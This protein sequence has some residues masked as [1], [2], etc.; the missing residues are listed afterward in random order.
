MNRDHAGK[1]MMNSVQML[2]GLVIALTL[3]APS[4]GAQTQTAEQKASSYTYQTLY[5]TNLFQQN[6]VS[7]VQSA[8]RNML[9]KAKLVAMPSQNAIS[10]YS[11][12]EE[13]L[14]AQRIVS[15][16]DRADRVRKTYRLTYT[17]T[18]TDSGKHI[19]TQHFALIV[20][21][22][23]KTVLK[24]GNRVPIVTGTYDTETVMH[25]TQLQYQD[26]GLSIEATVI[27]YGNG[28]K[29]SSHFEQSS[30]AEEKSGV[31]S[32]DPV[33]RQ[34]LLVGSA[35]LA[36]GKPLVLGSLDVPGGTSKREIEVVS[37]LVR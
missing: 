6:E 26:V 35:T 15:D 7:D 32:Q 22:G 14:L 5:L 23:E 36:L 24:Q 20:V 37:E 27:G 4:A 25:A 28:L 29:L 16:F 11:T 9:P 34:T 1:L 21:S 8:L 12:P 3:F 18:E 33:L 2:V 31:G 30:I 10:I 13:I 19:G 17:I